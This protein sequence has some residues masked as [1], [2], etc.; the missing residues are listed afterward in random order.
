VTGSAGV[1]ARASLR[2]SEVTLQVVQAAA[3]LIGKDQSLTRSVN[4]PVTAEVPSSRLASPGRLQFKAVMPRQSANSF[5]LYTA[6]HRPPPGPQVSNS[7]IGCERVY[8]PVRSRASTKSRW[9]RSPTLCLILGEFEVL[10]R[11]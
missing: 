9:P 5:L 7:S 8:A 3:M 2:L 11:E 10:S 1:V 4:Q 6:R